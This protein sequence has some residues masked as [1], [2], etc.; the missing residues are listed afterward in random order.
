MVSG[1]LE[2]PI[3][4]QGRILVPP[5]LREHAALDR[6]VTI[7]GVGKRIELWDKS[8]FDQDLAMTKARIGEISA[9]VRQFGL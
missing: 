5:Y 9:A 8:R 1:A 2:C 6:D 4:S 3:D 7:A